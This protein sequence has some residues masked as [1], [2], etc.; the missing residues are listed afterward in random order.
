MGDRKSNQIQK[1]EGDRSRSVTLPPAKINT[2]KP[3]H[4]LL[5]LQRQLG[6]RATTELIQ[7]KLTVGAVND[8]YEQEA[9]R[10]ADRVMRMPEVS[11]TLQLQAKDRIQAKSSV[12]TTPLV[13]PILEQ[14]IQSMRGGGQPLAPDLRQFYEPRM[15]YPLGGVRL[16]TDSHA[17][18]AANQL[19]AKAFTL[20]S[21]I[22]FASGHYEPQTAQ[23]K[24]LLAHELTH[25][26][27][28]TPLIS[29]KPL[30]LS[31]EN[32]NS[33]RIWHDKQTEV[34][35]A[36]QPFVS[37]FLMLDPDAEV[38]IRGSLATGIK[39]NPEKIAANGE[40]YLF[41][42]SDFDIDAYV[43]SD[44]LYLEALNTPGGNDAS[45][46][47][48]ISGTKL[49][50]VN[51]IIKAMRLELGKIPGNRDKGNKAWRFNVL[52]RSERNA[53]FTTKKDRSSVAALG[54]NANDGNPI[55][56]LPPD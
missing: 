20:G 33:I 16:H 38:K 24:W 29:C 44:A 53:D 27:Q 52:I 49:P 54:F 47:G 40:R 31:Q 51:T 30:T 28:Q 48:Q 41:D 3:T 6:N 5:S 45:A 36:M 13:T 12:E 8:V 1:T 43:V 23:G 4:P 26:I 10:T 46:R 2:P 55:R 42:P 14:Q 34:N 39:M 35:E 9:D 50:S 18:S 37:Q 25:T 56:I 11:S 7:A 17:N 32:K 19:Q 22:F 21:D 15:G